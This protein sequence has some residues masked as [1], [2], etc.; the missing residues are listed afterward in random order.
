MVVALGV[1]LSIN[2]QAYDAY[3]D[4]IYYNLNADTNTAEVTYNK[5][6]DDYRGDIVIPKCIE[7]Q[8]VKYNVTSIGEKAF[9]GSSQLK[10]VSIPDG[11]TSIGEDAFRMCNLLTSVSLP[12]SV[13]SIGKGAFRCA[14]LRTTYNST[15]FAHLHE[16]YQGAYTIPDGIT[17]ICAEAFY[18]CTSLTSVVI[19]N[20][21]VSIGNV[22]F[23]GCSSLTSVVLPNSVTE[24]DDYAFENC[25]W[26]P[27]N[28]YKQ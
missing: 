12:N 14:R 13:T 19:P 5:G 4:G 7:Y 27:L 24:I 17:Q 16:S 25:I 22:A 1:L 18:G 3:I 10:T 20:N 9:K 23:F 6:K 26:R 11:V 15:C 28:N 8:N 21:V 2:A